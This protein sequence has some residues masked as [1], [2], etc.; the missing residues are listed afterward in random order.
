MVPVVGCTSA[1]L[2]WRRLGNSPRAAR[3][4]PSSGHDSG[5]LWLATTLQS[6]SAQSSE[7]GVKIIVIDNNAPMH[8]RR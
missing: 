3:S 7:A 4:H 2:S 8:P 5:S 1:E 6:L